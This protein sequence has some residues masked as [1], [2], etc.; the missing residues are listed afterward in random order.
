MAIARMT[1]DPLAPAA[2]RV[3]RAIRDLIE[4]SRGEWSRDRMHAEDDA[5]AKLTAAL[6]QFAE[7]CGALGGG[8]GGAAEIVDPQEK[9]ST[10]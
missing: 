2:S 6:A 8:A 10:Y 1:P 4:A 9:T 7:A 3:V 5:H